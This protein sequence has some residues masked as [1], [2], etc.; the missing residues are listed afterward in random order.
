M[1]KAASVKGCFRVLPLAFLPLTFLPLTSPPP[2][3]RG[4]SGVSPFCGSAFLLFLLREGSG[5][6]EFG[7]QDLRIDDG[8]S[9]VEFLAEG[10]IGRFLLP[11]GLQGCRD[12]C[13]GLGFVS[14][15]RGRILAPGACPG[16]D[17]LRG[18]PRRYFGLCGPI[19]G[20]RDGCRAFR[21]AL[22]WWRRIR[23]TFCSW[24][25]SLL[26]FRDVSSR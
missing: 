18:V 3:C 15:L 21:R 8:A 4:H 17:C 16:R 12:V 6:L 10:R 9:Q 7:L 25:G 5:L 20:C 26:S 24:A 22:C 2:C 23:F 14:G 11:G 13:F 1:E 19:S